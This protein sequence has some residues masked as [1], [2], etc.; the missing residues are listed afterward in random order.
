MS[1]KDAEAAVR[2][3][4]ASKWNNTT[5][6]AWPDFRFSTPAGTWVRFSMK[7]TMGYQASAGNPGN[8]AYRRKGI[9]TI[10]IFQ[11]E[12]KG[13][14]DARAKA[15]LAASAFIPPNRLAGFRFT[16]VNARDIGPDGN[17]WYQWNVTAEYEYDIAA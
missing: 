9:V 1:F 15:D 5:P 11:P 3:Y 7:N 6:I 10:Q 16:N 8:N 12:N 4:F 17:G 14:T 2:A 13:S